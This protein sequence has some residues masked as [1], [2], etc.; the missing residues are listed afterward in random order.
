MKNIIAELEAYLE[1][2]MCYLKAGLDNETDPIQR[3]N[4]AWYCIQRCLGTVQFANQLGADFGTVEAMFEAF[5]E[6]IVEMVNNGA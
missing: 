2:E 1:T 4:I 3:S 6:K 5:K